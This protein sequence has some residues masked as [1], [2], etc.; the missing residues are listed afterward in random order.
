MNCAYEGNYVKQLHLLSTSKVMRKRHGHN[1]V[2]FSTLYFKNDYFYRK[3]QE[4]FFVDHLT[5]NNFYNASINLGAIGR[6]IFAKN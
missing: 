5:K 6:D 1:V 3:M 2:V 4:E